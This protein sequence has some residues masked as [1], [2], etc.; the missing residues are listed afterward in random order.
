MLTTSAF[1]KGV[2]RVID[3]TTFN[4]L[5][6]TVVLW[7]SAGFHVYVMRQRINYYISSRLR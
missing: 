1:N 2:N 7:S 4:L 3:G 6:H 5:L